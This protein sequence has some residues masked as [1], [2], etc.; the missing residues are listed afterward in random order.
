METPKT[1]AGAFTEMVMGR[2]TAKFAAN[3]VEPLT[4]TQYNRIYECV[5]MCAEIH[6]A[7]RAEE[8]Q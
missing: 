7:D 1:F 5:L 2:I 3:N 6:S 8:S 4:T